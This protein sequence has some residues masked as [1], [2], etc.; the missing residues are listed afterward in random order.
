M[1]I[2]TNIYLLEFLTWGCLSRL[3]CLDSLSN[4]DS[5]LE[6]NIA[7]TLFGVVG[8]FGIALHA[9]NT[10]PYLFVLM[11]S[12]LVSRNTCL[13][14]GSLCNIT[15]TM[16]WKNHQNK[17]LLGLVMGRQIVHCHSPTYV[18]S[19]PLKIWPHLV[20]KLDYPNYII[21]VNNQ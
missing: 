14:H 13:L 8:A 17:K 18:E 16:G 7:P 19:W 21:M 2:E 9:S 20:Y 3:S 4:H 10:F 5:S 15:S 1:L 12:P 11:Y 6:R